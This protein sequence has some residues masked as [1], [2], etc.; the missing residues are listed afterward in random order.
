MHT[1]RPVYLQFQSLQ[2]FWPSIQVLHGSNSSLNSA[3][4]TYQNFFSLFTRFE[5]LPERFILNSNVVHS[6]QRMYGLRPE[7]MES[8]LYLYELVS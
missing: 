5:S 4:E 6:T 1:G 2:A 8:T 7:L 3:I